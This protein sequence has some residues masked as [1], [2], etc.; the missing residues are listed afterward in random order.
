MKIRTVGAELFHV[1][2][3]TDMTKYD[4][5]LPQRS[6]RTASFCVITQRIAVISN[7]RLRITYW[8]HLSCWDQ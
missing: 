5:R 8:S 3:R 7:R 2:G 1:D 6:M 4:F